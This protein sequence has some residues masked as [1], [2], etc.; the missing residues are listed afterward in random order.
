M[1]QYLEVLTSV[2]PANAEIKNV[3]NSGVARYEISWPLEDEIR[4]HKRSKIIDLTFSRELTDDISGLSDKD[5]RAAFIK[6][7]AI[8]SAK[9]NNFDQ[10]HNQPNGSPMEKWEITNQF[11]IES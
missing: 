2:M 11:L 4:K 3:P 8:I 7:S 6:I 5:K 9:L 10:N 1:K